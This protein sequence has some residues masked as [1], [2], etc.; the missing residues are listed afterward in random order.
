MGQPETYRFLHVG[1]ENGYLLNYCLWH[2][3][4]VVS[5]LCLKG[6]EVCALRKEG[7]PTLALN[8][9]LAYSYTSSTC[10][11]SA[12]RQ[13]FRAA[14]LEGGLGITLAAP[15]P[16]RSAQAKSF[17]PA[18]DP[19]PFSA[20]GLQVKMAAP[21]SGLSKA[22]YV[23]QRYLDPGA[24]KQGEEHASDA[25]KRCKKRRKRKKENGQGR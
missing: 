7:D 1:S 5:F 23:R 12:P 18:A 13:H 14:T 15:F 2:V 3:L 25:E 17:G 10:L 16:F 22:E 4:G 9:R 20:S 11:C 19:F 24:S 21:A 6:W 8:S